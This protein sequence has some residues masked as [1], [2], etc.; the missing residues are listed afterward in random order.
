[1]LVL[2]V[3]IAAVL[4]FFLPR[5]RGWILEEIKALTDVVIIG[6]L[7]RSS[8]FGGELT[9]DGRGEQ[10]LWREQRLRNLRGLA[11]RSREAPGRK[12]HPSVN[13]AKKERS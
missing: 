4:L 1:M 9:E 13:A 2:V 5:T 8:R 12:S 3:V 7:R 10:K 11:L 6:F